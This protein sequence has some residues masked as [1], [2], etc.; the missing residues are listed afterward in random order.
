MNQPT[1]AQD[2]FRLTFDI[3]AHGADPSDLLD[4]LIEFQQELLGELEEEED[5]YGVLVSNEADENTCLVE[6]I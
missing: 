1:A 5:T 6:Q 4:R 2:T 3:V